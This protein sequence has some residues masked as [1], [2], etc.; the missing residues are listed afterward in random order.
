VLIFRKII[1]DQ[2]LVLNHF[3]D[4]QASFVVL[5]ITAET[6]YGSALEATLLSSSLPFQPPLTVAIG[7]LI[8]APRSLSP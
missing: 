5:T 4:L 1:I 6:A 7:I 8:D 2:F 3:I